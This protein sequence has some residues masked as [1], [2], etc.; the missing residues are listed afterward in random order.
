MEHWYDH[1][2]KS[3]ETSHKG[4]VNTLWKQKMQTDRNICNNKLGV[5]TRD[6]GKRTGRLIDTALSGDRNVIKES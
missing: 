5:L 3:V 2:P 4:K 6:N 1:V